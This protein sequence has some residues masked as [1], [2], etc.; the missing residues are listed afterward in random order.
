MADSI[1][2]GSIRFDPIRFDPIAAVC[3]VRLDQKQKHV[4]EAANL[5][6]YMHSLLVG[7]VFLTEHC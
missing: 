5:L 4:D 2:S 1:R 3:G 7:D 6:A